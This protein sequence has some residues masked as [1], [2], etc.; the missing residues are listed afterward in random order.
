MAQVGTHP[1]DVVEFVNRVNAEGDAFGYH[2]IDFGDGLVMDGE[3][4][5]RDYLPEYGIPSDLTGKT[6]LDVGTASGFFAVEFAKRGGTVTAVD[7]WDG[8]FQRMVFRAAGVD[9]RY[10]Q[11]DLF[12][13]D[14]GFGRFDL[15]FCGSVL[16]HVWDQFN[17]LRRLRSVCAGQAIVATAVRGR[18]RLW[19]WPRSSSGGLSQ[20]VGTRVESDAGEYWVTWIPDPHALVWMMKK[21]GFEPVEYQ[22]NFHLRSA[23]GHHD[24]D[25]LH[26]VVHGF[27][28]G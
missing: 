25:T 16:L 15:V 18:G 9:V 3:Y 22:G 24:Y 5:M 23:P 19:P 8:D 7:I 2:R 12:D 28:S 6:V 1:A 4:D 10:E 14:E 20:F 11:K 21:A 17:A 27:T 26:G 13:L